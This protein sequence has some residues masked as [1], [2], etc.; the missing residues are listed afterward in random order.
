MPNYP[1]ATPLPG[2][3]N[4]L[5]VTPPR[6]PEF[7]TPGLNRKGAVVISPLC[8]NRKGAVGVYAKIAYTHYTER[9]PAE[10]AHIHGPLS[11]RALPARNL[12]FELLGIGV[13]AIIGW[14][15]PNNCPING[16]YWVGPRKPNNHPHLVIYPLFFLQ[17]ALTPI[18]VS[19][20]G[21]VRAG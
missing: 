3:Q 9:T 16:N 6:V 10:G 2:L 12:I 4:P 1:P 8:P 13:W 20:P 17:C 14:H 18:S 15:P 11:P 21:G 5:R 19:G 7:R